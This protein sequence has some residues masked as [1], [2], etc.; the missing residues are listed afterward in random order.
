MKAMTPLRVLSCRISSWP[1]QLRKR[2][3]QIGR[4]TQAQRRHR[5][6]DGKEMENVKGCSEI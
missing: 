4:Q 6:K 2:D 5:Q 3:R 1:F